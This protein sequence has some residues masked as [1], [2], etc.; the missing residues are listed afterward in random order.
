MAS[1]AHLALSVSLPLSLVLGW[2]AGGV[3]QDTA[4]NETI[5]V[6]ATWI[7]ESTPLTGFDGIS[8]IRDA[9]MLE[10]TCASRTDSRGIFQCRVQCDPD[11][12]GDEMIQFTF[13]RHSNLPGPGP[14]KYWLDHTRCESNP[15]ERVTVTYQARIYASVES[16]D[17]FQAAL[18][19]SSYAA[20]QPQEGAVYQ[21]R[22]ALIS[23]SDPATLARVQ[24]D[25]ADLQYLNLE[26]D[27]AEAVRYGDMHVFA[28]AAMNAQLAEQAGLS[29]APLEDADQLIAYVEST[30][31]TILAEGDFSQTAPG[32]QDRVAALNATLEQSRQLNAPELQALRDAYLAG[33]EQRAS[34]Q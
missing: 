1:Y 13:D 3:A 26:T 11:I 7:V 25:L 10:T 14:V 23:Q 27:A 15:A 5:S 19:A 20:I 34:P 18:G 30:L 17:A 16:T 8:V 29:V 21:S 9:D 22:F 24:E 31:D 4:T 2:P 12:V 32:F 6:K 28:V 33:S